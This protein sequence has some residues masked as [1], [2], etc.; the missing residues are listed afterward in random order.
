MMD[1]THPTKLT[2]RRN[3]RLFEA[4]LNDSDGDPAFHLMIEKIPAGFYFQIVGINDAIKTIAKKTYPDI[5]TAQQAAE[6]QTLSIIGNMIA[7]LAYMKGIL[8]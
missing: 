7:E 6:K 8:E 2:W 5:V 4:F 1:D 3:Y